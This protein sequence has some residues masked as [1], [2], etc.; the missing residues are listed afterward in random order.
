MAVKVRSQLSHSKYPR[1]FLDLWTDSSCFTS[2][3]GGAGMLEL[4]LL[5]FLGAFF[6]VMVV[7]GWFRKSNSEGRSC[8]HNTSRQGFGSGSAFFQSLDPDP[9]PD[10]CLIIQQ[11]K[12]N[13]ITK[14]NFFTF[15]KERPQTFCHKIQFFYILKISFKKVFKYLL[16]LFHSKN[17]ALDPNQH[18]DPYPVPH[19][20]S[21]PWLRIR[22]KWMRIRNPA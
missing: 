7:E 17:Q 22:K 14:I 13:C 6:S 19:S 3:G 5:P 8:V 10:P 20:F 18:P 21:K 16:L 1:L 2:A 11:K 4:A 9:N 15:L 12:K